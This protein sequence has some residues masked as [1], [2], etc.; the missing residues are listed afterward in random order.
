MSSRLAV[1]NGKRATLAACLMTSLVSQACAD[2][3]SGFAAKFFKE[4]LGVAGSLR[5]A[6]FPEDRAFN[7]ETHFGVVGGWLT[8]S[9]REFLY[10]TKTYFDVRIQNQNASRTSRFDGEIREA[11]AQQSFG[12]VDLRAG[13]Q[14]TV[15]GRADKVNPTDVW[16]VR[17]L[18]LLA[19]EDED[20]R[21][22]LLAVQGILN[23]GDNRLIALWQPEWRAPGLPS[24]TPLAKASPDKPWRQAGF[25]W[26]RSG[27]RADFS[28]SYAHV[29]DRLPDVRVG[30]GTGPELA[31]HFID[32]VGAD[33]SAPV[34]H[35]GLR[36]EAAYT[37]TADHKGDDPL[38]QNAGLFA[39]F[40]IERTF[41]GELN[42]NAQYLYKRT[43]DFPDANAIADSNARRAAEQVNLGSNQLRAN[44]HGVTLRISHKA[45]NETLESEFT[46]VHWFGTE[47][48]FL[49]PKV[50]YSV[51]DNFRVIAGA[52]FYDGPKLSVFGRLS[53]IST[54]Y[55]ELRRYF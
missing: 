38:T 50:T 27:E 29:L 35:Y 2:E 40:G 3:G 47:D 7:G 6:Y 45:L 52:E 24:Q 16:S 31:F 26:D 39:V 8:A 43:T 54:G 22:G 15:W 53:E 55:L 48:T 33:F 18:R 28:V 10:G 41:G 25:K 20:Q 4:D 34:G 37:W 49:R 5:G 19:P 11:Y 13:R 51:S 30:S 44:E 14:I 23:V 36:G 9:P 32:V 1:L 46:A 12:P 17:D 21:L 42:A